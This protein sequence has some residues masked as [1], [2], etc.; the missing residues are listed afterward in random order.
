VTLEGRSIEPTERGMLH[1]IGAAL[2]SRAAR[3]DAIAAKIRARRRRVILLFDNFEVL[4]LTDTWIRQKLLPA[5]PA[6]ARIVLSGRNPPSPAWSIAAGLGPVLRTLALGPLD[7]RDSAALLVAEGLSRRDVD[8]V[9]RFAEGYP[10]ALKLAAWSLRRHAPFAASGRKRTRW[11]LGTGSR[12]RSS[13]QRRS[14]GSSRAGDQRG[15]ADSNR[16]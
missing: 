12:R 13:R 2:G 15:R 10:L 4:G 16:Q 5:L 8:R 3:L 14:I 9:R 6:N 7:A 11:P 1:A